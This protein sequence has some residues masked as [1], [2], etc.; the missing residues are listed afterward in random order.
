MEAVGGYFGLELRE[1]NLDYPFLDNPAVN[2]GRHALEFI[3]RNLEVLPKRVYIPYYTCEVLLE[4][5]RRLGINHQFYHINEKLEID[6]HVN[7]EKDEYII[8][9]N[10]FGIKDRY[11]ERLIFKYKNQ[12]I[13]DSA[14][15]FFAPKIGGAKM[16]FSPRKFIGV[17]DGGYTWPTYDTDTVSEQD[18]STDRSMHL[19]RRIDSGA[20][21]GYED[22][23][24][25]DE[26]LS[27]M[28]VRKMSDLT[29]SILE[30]TDCKRIIERRREN[31]EILHI[32]LAAQNRLNIPDWDTF[33]CP[34]VY[35]FWTNDETL[36]KRLINNKIFVATYWPNVFDWCSQDSLE[37]ELAKNLIPL[38]LDQRYGEEEMNRIIDIITNK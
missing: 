19:F 33:K 27:H 7:L 21:S 38:P 17:A 35:P 26:S 23:Q 30:S 11:I 20:E 1:K 36:R 4:P 8:A 14:Q 15:A 22:F 3:L 29:R 28:P 25:D 5:L 31:F 12:L 37:Y 10:Y 9:N 18:L 32:A 6:G 13:I 34:M 24:R 2:S 16:F